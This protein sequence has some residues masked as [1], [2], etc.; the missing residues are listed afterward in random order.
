M[1]V[2]V[3]W[4]S[5]FSSST[6]AQANIFAVLP[7]GIVSLPISSCHM[8]TTC[9]EC[10]ASPDP[11]CQW[12]PAAGKCTTAVHCSSPSVSVCPLQNGPPSP[13]SLSIDDLRNISLPIKHLPQP[14]GFSYVCIF[15]SSSSA[16]S[17]TQQGVSC[18]LPSLRSSSDLPSSLTELLALSTST[19]SYRIVEY[20]F[21]IYNC[22]A[23]M[24]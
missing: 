10:V 2:M 7:K 3:E 14:D 8:I 15:G 20:N 6:F 13:A 9:S 18:A 16:A 4:V 21:T 1:L 19:S 17:W 24:T 5:R 11:M 22:G 23:F 12:C